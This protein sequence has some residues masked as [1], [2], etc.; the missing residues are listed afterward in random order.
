MKPKPPVSAAAR[1]SRA[2]SAEAV[3]LSMKIAPDFTPANAPSFADGDG[4][5]IIVIADA[6]KDEVGAF[7][8]VPSE[9]AIAPPNSPTHFCALAR[10]G[11]RP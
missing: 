6:G 1:N 9:S 10:S 4:A 7:C 2:T 8:G 3:V 5:Q 11:C